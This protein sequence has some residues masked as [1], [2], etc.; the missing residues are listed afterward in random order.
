MGRGAFRIGS[1]GSRVSCV[2]QPRFGTSDIAVP[3]ASH[4]SPIINDQRVEA[5]DSRLCHSEARQFPLFPAAHARNS[6]E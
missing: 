2:I 6:A 3:R 1:D 5:C 4:W